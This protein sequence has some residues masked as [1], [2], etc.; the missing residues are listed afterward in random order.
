MDT[1]IQNSNNLNSEQ[2]NKNKYI[3]LF[4]LLLFVLSGCT[5]DFEEMNTD[6]NLPVDVPI[7]NHLAGTMI[8]FD[9]WYM[10]IAR[11][12]DYH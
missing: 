6:P 7:A 3:M 4:V 10:P 12:P 9:G 2:M 8:D 11:R 1:G 5:N